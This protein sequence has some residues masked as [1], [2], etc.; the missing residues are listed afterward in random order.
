MAPK[1]FTTIGTLTLDNVNQDLYLIEDF[2][3]GTLAFKEV[4]IGYHGFELFSEA[5]LDEM[6]GLDLPYVVQCKASDRS[7][8]KTLVNLLRKTR[9]LRLETIVKE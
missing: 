7:N 3:A 4:Y 5:K 1:P 9:K 8:L 6:I 2:A